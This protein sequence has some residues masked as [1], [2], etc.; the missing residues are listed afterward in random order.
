MVRPT[1]AA[2][3]ASAG[4][5]QRIAVRRDH[6]GQR[7]PVRL[8]RLEQPLRLRL[9]GGVPAVRHLVAGQELAH[10]RRAGRP[11]VPDDLGLRHRPVVRGHP[12]LEQRVD[13]RVELLLRR[14]PRLEQVVVE[15]DHV[16]RVDR[17][18]G[19]G[20][21]GEQHP[22]RPGVDVHR[23]L[24]ELDPVHLRH[25]VVGQQDRDQV[26]AQLHL[27]QRVQRLRARLGPHDAVMVAVAPAQVA[28]DR[29]GDARV[30]VDGEDRRPDR[31]GLLGHN[32][33]SKCVCV[34]V[35]RKVPGAYFGPSQYRLI[36]NACGQGNAALARSASGS[37]PGLRARPS[38]ARSGPRRRAGRGARCR[39][40]RDPGL[41]PRGRVPR[42][43]SFLLQGNAQGGHTA[44]CVALDRARL[45]PIAVAICAS[46]RSA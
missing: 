14:V 40:N 28:G 29:A 22:A 5:D 31:L 35:P 13:H 45:I 6:H 10:L 16:D 20:V 18:A 9:V 25:P 39:R 30:V 41:R 33:H 19:V 34:T 2:S 4:L 42:P 21:R 27:P 8:R 7:Q 1:R 17:G 46:D 11:A 24:E 43:P 23:L 3:S 44:G 12:R 32:A 37:G 15:V 38:T 36:A 26:A